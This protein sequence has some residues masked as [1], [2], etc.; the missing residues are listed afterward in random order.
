MCGPR[1]KAVEKRNPLVSGSPGLKPEQ[2]LF[3]RP[4]LQPHETQLLV[5]LCHTFGV[6]GVAGDRN[7]KGTKCPA[8]PDLFK[9]IIGMSAFN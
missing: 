2:Q 7:S 8:I 4:H 9:K 1:Q 5:G 3:L 6:K